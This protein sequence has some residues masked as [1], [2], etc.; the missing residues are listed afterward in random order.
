MCKFWALV[1]TVLLLTPL[2][3]SSARE[4]PATEAAEEL[5]EPGQLDGVAFAQAAGLP[6]NPGVLRA[7]HGCAARAYEPLHAAD[8]VSM[9]V[10]QENARDF[11][12]LPPRDGQH[13]FGITRIDH[14]AFGSTCR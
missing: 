8:M 1:F 3:F 7:E 6:R 14:R 2:A 5:P 13:R 9:V 12:F 10:G 11:E 4:R